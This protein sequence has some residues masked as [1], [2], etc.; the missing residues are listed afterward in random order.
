MVPLAGEIGPCLLA[1][2]GTTLKC[3]F[4]KGFHNPT[5]VAR[6]YIMCSSADATTICSVFLGVIAGGV[7]GD[8]ETHLDTGRTLPL[9][10][11]GENELGALDNE[12][13][14]T[15]TSRGT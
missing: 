9:R 8:G 15:E 10:A 3:L 7:G 5:S 1:W 2:A 12:G 14:L 11:E 4:F 6:I 13:T